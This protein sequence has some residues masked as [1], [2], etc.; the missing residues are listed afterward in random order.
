[1]NE[2]TIQDKWEHVKGAVKETGGDLTEDEVTHTEGNRQ[3][4]AG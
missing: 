1:M 3:K 4:P 2:N